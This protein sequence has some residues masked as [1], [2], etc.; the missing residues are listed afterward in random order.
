MP[1]PWLGDR[2]GRQE[3][4]VASWG[5]SRE[6]VFGSFSEGMVPRGPKH[7]RKMLESEVPKMHVSGRHGRVTS[8]RNPFDS[9]LTR[10]LSVRRPP[11]GAVPSVLCV[12][13][14][15]TDGIN[16]RVYTLWLTTS[17]RRDGRRVDKMHSKCDVCVPL[18]GRRQDPRAIALIQTL[19]GSCEMTK[20][21][22]LS[23]GCSAY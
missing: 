9:V 10:P 22:L 1:A 4:A 16:R 6:S 3:G 2:S 19:H 13:R 21:R 12:S 23:A 20:W 15:R 8:E 14:P 5:A 18:Q 7:D 17:L 11:S